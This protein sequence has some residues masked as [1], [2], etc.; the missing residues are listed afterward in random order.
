MIVMA[1]LAAI[2]ALSASAA[3]A[4]SPVPTDALADLTLHHVQVSVADA[5]KLAA[6]YVEKLGFRVSKRVMNRAVTIVWIDI[7]GFR[8]GLAQVAGS[9]RDASQSISPPA[10]T[11]QQ[12]YRQ[13]HFSVPDVDAA[14]RQLIASGVR[15]AVP[16]TSY[17]ITHIRLATMLDPE[18][19]S[20]SLYEDLD[21]NNALLPPREAKHGETQP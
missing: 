13:L 15:F 20:V 18:G 6:W 3:P 5:D 16:P 9:H 1:A 19:N 8:L 11:M 17:A 7:P 10:D 21:P 12:G 2:G 4:S 14:Y